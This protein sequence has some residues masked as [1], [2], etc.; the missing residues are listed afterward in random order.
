MIK[1]NIKFKKQTSNGIIRLESKSE[2]K[3][4]FVNADISNS[5][6][7]AIAIAFKTNSDSGFIELSKDEINF[8]IRK[9]NAKRHLIN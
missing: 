1:V 8:I 7:E 2:I 5:K 3:D 4:L 9:L 6:K